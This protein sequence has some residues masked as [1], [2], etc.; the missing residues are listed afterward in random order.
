[1]SW[2]VRHTY[3][4]SLSNVRLTEISPMLFIT[5]ELSASAMLYVTVPNPPTLLSASL[6]VTVNKGCTGIVFS[7]TLAAKY[8]E[9]DRM[10]SCF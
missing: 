6:A 7:S 3:A 1:M 8:E 4:A 9:Y 2:L 10:K 5:N